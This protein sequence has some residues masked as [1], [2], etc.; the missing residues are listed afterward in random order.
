MEY[1]DLIRHARELA[2]LVGDGGFSATEDGHA[3]A[4]Q[5]LKTLARALREVAS[6]L[7][8]AQAALPRWHDPAEEKPEPLVDALVMWGDGED[9]NDLVPAIAHIAKD[10]KWRFSDTEEAVPYVAAWMEIPAFQ[11]KGGDNEA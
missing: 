1:R 9:D 8:R 5:A 4:Q 10:G 11:P 7:E 6:E 3:Y 2:A